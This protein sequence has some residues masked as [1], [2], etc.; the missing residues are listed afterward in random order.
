MRYHIFKLFSLTQSLALFI[1]LSSS[2]LRGLAFALYIPI[3]KCLFHLLSIYLSLLKY[4]HSKIYMLYRKIVA[5]V[6][7]FCATPY[8]NVTLHTF[9]SGIR[10]G[11][12]GEQRKHTHRTQKVG[13]SFDRTLKSSIENRVWNLSQFTFSSLP[14]LYFLLFHI[15]QSLFCSL[16]R[17]VVWLSSSFFFVSFVSSVLVKQL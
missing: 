7:L 17:S 8:S 11:K 1:F 10:S 4:F 9:G 16:A 3:P 5:F 14:F 2:L 6:S 13:N 15:T 12:K